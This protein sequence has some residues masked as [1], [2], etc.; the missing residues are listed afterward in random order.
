MS[1]MD[2]ELD[3]TVLDAGSPAN[4]VVV[5]RCGGDLAVERLSL[6]VLAGLSAFRARLE[7]AVRGRPGARPTKTEILQFGQELFGFLVRGTVLQLYNRLPATHI[8]IRILSNHSEVQ[9][10]PWE[11][12]QEPG[13]RVG[14]PRMAR[15]IIRIVPIVGVPALQA[16]GRPSKIRLLFVAADPADQAPIDWPEVQERIQ[17]TFAQQ[18]ADATGNP[19]VLDMRVVSAASRAA[20]A[21]EI[22]AQPLDILHFCG[23]GQ[24]VDGVGELLLLDRRTGRSASVP[25]PELCTLLRDRG[26]R[27][28]VLSAC[29]SAAG[30]FSDGFSVVAEA[31]V[32]IGIPA[33]VANQMPVYESTIA[34]FVGGMYAELLRSGDIDRAVGQGRILLA[35]RLETSALGVLEWGIPTLYRHF[36]N[37]RI[38]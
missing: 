19:T 10:L 23:H 4:A 36:A 29:D 24:V 21:R 31:L 7:S 14:G 33:V 15:S 8:R 22:A 5:A 13:E 27:L 2:E 6:A 30:N 37:P 11:Y 12:L 35:S 3:L 34:T 18:I 28:V 17:R 26:L 38:F 32:R 16:N 25:A 20:L 9:S 1:A